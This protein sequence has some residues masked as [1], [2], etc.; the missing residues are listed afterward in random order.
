MLFLLR[1]KCCS[2]THDHDSEAEKATRSECEGG[3]D[4]FVLM[5]NTCVY[6]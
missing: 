6:L 3:R 5:G 1:F 2:W 4:G